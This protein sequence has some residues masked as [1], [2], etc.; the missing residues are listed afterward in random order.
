V[1]KPFRI[2]AIHPYVEVRVSAHKRS[3]RRGQVSRNK[4]ITASSSHNRPASSSR[5]ACSSSRSACLFVTLGLPLRHT[6]PTI[7]SPLRANLGTPCIHLLVLH[8][9]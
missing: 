4:N 8:Q 7:W 9:L 5:S 2:H 6:R 1:K 3:E